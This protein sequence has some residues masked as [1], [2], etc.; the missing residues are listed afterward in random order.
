MLL[1]K[2]SIVLVGALVPILGFACESTN[3]QKCKEQ[4]GELVSYRAEA[5]ERAFGNLLE[6]LPAKIG[7][8]FVGP[9]DAEYKKYAR[10][11][12]YDPSQE[13]LIVPRQYIAARIPRPL[14]AS[15]YYWPFYEN[16]LYRETFPLITAVDNAL[17]GAYLQEAAQAR[18]L[19]W[20][21]ANCLSADITTRLPCEMLLAGVAEHLTAVRDPMFNTNRIEQI[22]PQDFE[23]F[24]SR[25][26]RRDDPRYMNVTRYGGLMLIKPLIDEFGVPSVLYYIAQTPFEIENDN[27]KES[28]LSYQEHAREWLEAHQKQHRKETT[29]TSVV[30][31]PNIDDRS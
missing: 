13:M 5:I 7:V 8:K 19:T 15:A 27:V 10:R 2:L 17:W 21:H 4:V 29:V 24:R 1:A 22:W 3:R 6:V 11:V 23:S 9:R 12:A 26:W 14:R 31:L 20:P 30:A 18:G 16:D 28:A 25:V